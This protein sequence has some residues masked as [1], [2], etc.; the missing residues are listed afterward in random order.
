MLVKPAPRMAVHIHHGADSLFGE[1]P[2]PVPG[3]AFTETWVDTPN[4][5]TLVVVA[6]AVVDV[7]LATT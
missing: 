3:K 4:P 2:D 1:S 5:D 6:V 7:E